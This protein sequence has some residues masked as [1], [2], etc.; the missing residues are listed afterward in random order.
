MRHRLRQPLQPSLR[1]PFLP[2]D[3]VGAQHEVV[4]RNARAA[5]MRAPPPAPTGG[6]GRLRRAGV[7]ERLLRDV[8][9]AVHLWQE[10]SAGVAAT[11]SDRYASGFSARPITGSC[12]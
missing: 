8:V 7:P 10:D 12:T 9:G 2:A 11:V 4:R 6:G 1:F 3:R 5:R